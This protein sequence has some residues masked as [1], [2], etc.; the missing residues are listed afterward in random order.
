M[1]VRARVRI[2][3]VLF[4]ECRTHTFCVFQCLA[5]GTTMYMF[6]DGDEVLPETFF[7]RR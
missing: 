7:K 3:N 2:M 4:Y 6:N 5:A 1:C